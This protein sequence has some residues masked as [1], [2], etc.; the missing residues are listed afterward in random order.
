MYRRTI[1]TTT[2]PTGVR[3]DGDEVEITVA[4]GTVEVYNAHGIYQRTVG[5]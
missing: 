4:N 5:G 1:R 3:S 2:I